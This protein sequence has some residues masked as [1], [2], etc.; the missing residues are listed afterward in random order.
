MT[1]PSTSY[2][3]I[4]TID[5]ELK[6]LDAIP[7]TGAAPSFPWADLSDRL[8]RAPLIEK[9]SRSNLKKLCGALKINFMMKTRRLSLF[10]YFCCSHFKRRNL[11]GH[12]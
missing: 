3:W 10:P 5:P 11:L 6:A 9:D 4:R 2:D 7:L 12:A 8:A 1:T